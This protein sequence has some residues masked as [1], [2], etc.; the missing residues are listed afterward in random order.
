MSIVNSYSRVGVRQSGSTLIE[1]LV[2]VAVT[3]VGLLGMVGLM[4][5]G[6]KANQDAYFRTQASFAAQALIESMRINV[7]AVGQ[8]LYNGSYPSNEISNPDCLQHGCT[9]QERATY[10]LARFNLALA[11][12]LPNANA[13]LKCT[14]DGPTTASYGNYEGICR[15]QLG[16]SERPLEQTTGVTNQ[17]LAWVFQP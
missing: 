2:A 10:D 4:A 7:P 15:L 6:A 12:N 11:N 1:V 13:K 17:S 3:S 8:G 9:S 16:W 14:D 5:V